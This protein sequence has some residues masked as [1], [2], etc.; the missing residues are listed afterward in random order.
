MI[1]LRLTSERSKG[2]ELTDESYRRRLLL[3]NELQALPEECLTRL[4][5]FQVQVGCANR[6]TFCSQSAGSDIWRF[7]SAGLSDI[8]AAVSRVIDIKNLSLGAGRKEHRPGVI[9]P[10]LDDD[11]FSYPNLLDLFKYARQDLKVKLRISTV[12]YSALN[13]GLNAMHKNI[14]AEYYSEFAGLRFSL[15]PYAYGFRMN[16]RQYVHDVAATLQ[17]YHS[18]S[19]RLGFGAKTAAVEL[20]FP[21]MVYVTEDDLFDSIVDGYHAFGVGAHLAISRS[22]NF[23]RP[24]IGQ[25][26][27]PT[28]RNSPFCTPPAPYAL[29]SGDELVAC[30]KT[31]VNG[32]IRR[33]VS[34]NL[35]RNV[36]VKHVEVYSWNNGDG[37]YYAVDPSFGADGSF[38]AMQFYPKGKKRYVSG[39]INSTRYFL[40]Q[41][42]A[43]KARQGLGRRSKFFSASW[44]DVH[45]VIN[46][47]SIESKSLERFDRLGAG[48]VKD[49]ILPLVEAYVE[50]LR[51][52][53]FSPRTFF[54]PTWTIDTGQIVN[55]GR[56]IRLFRGLAET[57][58]EPLSPHEDQAYGRISI[59]S[60]RGTVW[61]MAPV[62]IGLEGTLCLSAR[63]GRKN[64]AR[65][66][67][68]LI[69]EELDPRHL[70]PRDRETGAPLRRFFLSGVETELIK[71]SSHEASFGF[72]GAY[73][74]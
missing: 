71:A 67:W 60:S 46:G 65:E 25:I 52:A 72:P 1:D 7:T 33:V 42:I 19:E 70:L 15:S 45:S 17:M 50:I 22:R 74:G 58:D 54:D 5:F 66:G 9:F 2:I 4:Q 63:N 64:E 23:K 68:S 24:P 26:L 59:S 48:H 21:P 8:V 28:R 57:I 61:R 47:L 34:G 69:V 32:I 16:R 56:A 6:C 12:G 49:N 41:L 51:K 37:E 29:V 18:V 40:N 20:R 10:Y 44:D 11:I 55:Q 3:F 73:H 43:V 14:A 36:R 53:D 35:P 30:S 27:A 38:S 31:D 62:P 39:Y 13:H